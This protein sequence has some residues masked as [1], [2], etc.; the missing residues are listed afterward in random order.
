MYFL[1]YSWTETCVF[2]LWSSINGLTSKLL[3]LPIF[4]YIIIAY[5]SA[6]SC[7]KDHKCRRSR[8][9]ILFFI[10]VSVALLFIWAK[11][12]IT[13][14]EVFHGLLTGKICVALVMKVYSGHVRIHS[15]SELDIF[16]SL[17]VPSWTEAC[18]GLFFGGKS[19]FV[20]L[21]VK[22]RQSMKAV[23]FFGSNSCS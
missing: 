20:I 5:V 15:I 14:V 23:T 17:W 8:E 3:R 12:C 21:W 10:L 22:V 13:F 9:T 19:S 4:M 16:P 6:F 18:G 11:T 2:L 1:W 7:L